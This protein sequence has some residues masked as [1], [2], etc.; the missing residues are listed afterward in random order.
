MFTTRRVAVIEGDREAA[1]ML[2]TFFRLMEL[3]CSLI[4]PDF[5]AVPTVRRSHA[6]VLLLDLDLP[7]LRALDIAREIRRSPRHIPIIFMT[8]SHPELVP[9]DAPV[10]RK[11]RD[12][13]EELLRLFEMVLAFEERS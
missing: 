2:H 8:E 3:D 11:P 10:L 1:E 4:P 6:D 9:F 5:Q 7:D 12:R 13:F